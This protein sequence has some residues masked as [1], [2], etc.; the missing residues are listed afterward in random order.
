[1]LYCKLQKYINIRCE[2]N[3]VEKEEKIEIEDTASLYEST[4][5][6]SLQLLYFPS[7]QNNI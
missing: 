6:E 1:M 2:Q 3:C 5:L 4:Y 7:K